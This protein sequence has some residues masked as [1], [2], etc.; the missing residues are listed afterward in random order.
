MMPASHFFTTYF[1][2]LF[3]LLSSKKRRTLKL[4]AKISSPS[5]ISIMKLEISD[6]RDLICISKLEVEIT[7][8]RLKGK[9]WQD[10][11]LDSMPMWD[12]VT[13][14]RLR[15]LVLRWP[16]LVDFSQKFELQTVIPGILHVELSDNVDD[17]GAMDI[18]NL[19]DYIYIGAEHLS[20]Q[21]A[22]C[23]PRVTRT[24]FFVTTCPGGCESRGRGPGEDRS[25]CSIS[26]SRHSVP[27]SSSSERMMILSPAPGQ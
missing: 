13:V 1:K 25:P 22:R 27:R 24:K 18:L 12:F 5:P 8:L 4:K 14:S 6:C 16:H 21:E 11:F 15:L 26:S 9:C 10:M 20:L 23:S 7:G 2:P 3:S 19:P 17:W